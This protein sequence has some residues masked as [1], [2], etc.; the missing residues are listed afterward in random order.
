MVHNLQGKMSQRLL[1]ALDH[2]ARVGLGEGD[3]EVLSSGFPEGFA[4]GV[5]SVMVVGVAGES[6]HVADEAGQVFISDIR[7]KAELVLQS[8]G[9]SQDEIHGG[10]GTIV[11]P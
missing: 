1:R 9:E 11:S 6:V 4:L 10:A 7:L 3:T 5:E 2:F 8:D